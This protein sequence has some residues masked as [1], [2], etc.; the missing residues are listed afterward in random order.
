MI[1]RSDQ[2]L[3]SARKNGLVI[4]NLGGETLVYDTLQNRAHCLN[5]NA[6]FIWGHCDGNHTVNDLSELMRSRAGN[7]RVSQ[8]KSLELA[9]IALGQLQSSNLLETPIELPSEMRGMTRRQLIKAAGIAALVA[10]PVISSMVA[11]KAAQA[12]TCLASG[13]PCTSSAECCSGL[14]NVNTC[15]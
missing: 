13:Q 8:E 12:A 6:A 10:V 9:W 15:A 7:H 1:S 4:Q 5:E 11:P 14:C 3:P 2:K